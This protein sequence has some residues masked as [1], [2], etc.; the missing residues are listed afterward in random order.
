M[1]L[2]V[3]EY[4]DILFHHNC[5]D[6]HQC[7]NHFHS[8]VLTAIDTKTFNFII[9]YQCKNHFLSTSETNCISQII[10]MWHYVRNHFKHNIT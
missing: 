4:K 2:T 8:S 5:Y 1:V 6:K 7:A 10:L 9:A 3:I